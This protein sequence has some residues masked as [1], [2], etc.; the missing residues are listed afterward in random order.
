VKIPALR[1]RLAATDPAV[2]RD[3]G[4]T[5]DETLV[6]AVKRFQAAEGLEADGR[7]GRMT[8]AALNRPAQVAV[9][10]LRVALDMRRAMA[11]PP[12]ERRIEVN[13][14]YQRLAVIEAGRTLLEMNVIVGKPARPTP[15]MRVRLTAIQFNPRWGVPMRNAKED[16]LPRFRRDPRAMMEKGF[17][18]YSS[19]NGQ[20]VEIN[21][22]T[23]V[24]NN[25]NPEH[26]P[27]IIRQDAGEA[28]ALGRIKFIIPNADDIF[29]HDTPERNLFSRPD[30][31]FSSGCIRL[32]KPME[33]LDIALAGMPG[34]DRARADKLLAE[35]VTT[36]ITVRQAMPT[37][38]HYTT[39]VVEGSRV[40]LRSDLYGL[41]AAYLR[42]MDAPTRVA[43]AGVR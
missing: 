8:L 31:A 23:I 33:L 35:H 29:M 4:G 9:D 41:D 32:E 20:L 14:P 38:L 6:A 18:V 30:R 12:A 36:G 26:F 10:Q 19:V 17:R 42:A 28:N 5:Y 27:Y 39:A 1:A 24:W 2:R 37:R 13:V 3:G 21:P 40:T 15:M 16:L 43:A 34:W 11:A 7:I 25:V 22:T